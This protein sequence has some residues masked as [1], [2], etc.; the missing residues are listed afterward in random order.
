M[1]RTRL[2][3]CGLIA[4]FLLATASAAGAQLPADQMKTLTLPEP[5]PNWVFV[6]DGQYPVM[7]ISKLHIID[8]DSRKLLGQLFGGYASNFELAPDHRELYLIDTY[9]SRATRGTRTDVVSIFDAKTLGWLGEIEI[10]PKRLIIV[11]KE[12]TTGLTPDGRFLFVANMTP[13]TSVTV[14]DLKARKFVGEIDTPGCAQV[15]VAGQRSFASMCAD[16]SLMTVQ[17][18]D[19]GK[20]KSRKQGKPFFDPSRDPVFDQPVVVGGKAYFVSYHGAIHVVDVSGDEAK[21]EAEW[22]MLTPEDQ[23]GKWRPGGWQVIAARDGAKQLYVM[24]HQGGEWTHK[25]FGKEVW[26]LDAEKR[27]RMARIKLK[28]DAYSINVS[29]GPKPLLYA[30]DLLKS[31]LETYALPSGKYEGVYKELGTPFLVYRP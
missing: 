31:Q 21:G 19:S 13:A 11:P 7:M 6:L 3:S 9:Y 15:L 16:G 10:P 23:K 28:S 22:S 8:G 17:V 30:L 24:M 27:A 26:V 5:A 18:D 25:Q 4:L 20:L 1:A 29:E 2:N 12:N 14:V